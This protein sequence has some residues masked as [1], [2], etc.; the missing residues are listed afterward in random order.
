[1]SLSRAIAEEA[2]RKLW[3]SKFH[4]AGSSSNNTLAIADLGCSSGPNTLFA[5][6][7]LIKVVEKLCKEQGRESPEFQVFLNDLPR[8]DFNTIFRSSFHE[9]LKESLVF[10][11]GVAGS[12]YGRLFPAKTLHLVH[13]S[14]AVQWLSQLPPGLD[15]SN[16]GNIYISTSCSPPGVEEVYQRQFH[17]DFSL[18]LRCRSQEL[19][20]GGRMVLTII[21]RRSQYPSAK[22]GCYFWHLLSLVLNQMASEGLIDKDKLGS[23]NIPEYMPSPMEVE[24]EVKNEGSFVI[25]Q[26]QVSEVSWDAHDHEA[27]GADSVANC[28]RA[29]AEPL[30]VNHFG[31]GEVMIDEVFRRYRAIVSTRIANDEK[32]GS[33]VF[34]TVSLTNHHTC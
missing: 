14:C 23:F 10:I 8:N 20:I 9:K 24:A 7:E 22:E 6:S 16:R 12:F 31:D 19:V 2:M 33:F 11:N 18:F 29:V 15:K 30:M 21:G 17:K 3:S 27:T 4:A 25:D 28:I 32:T 5:V 34:V 26:L 13:S 1:M